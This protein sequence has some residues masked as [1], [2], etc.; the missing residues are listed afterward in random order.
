[1]KRMLGVTAVAIF[2]L[3]MVGTTAAQSGPACKVP[4][5]YHSRYDLP[6]SVA[7]LTI[8]FTCFEKLA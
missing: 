8:A 2:V 5:T 3:F 1:M 4:F 6:K 7:A